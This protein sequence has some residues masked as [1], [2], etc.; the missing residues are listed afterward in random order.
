MAR[1]YVCILSFAS[2]KSLYLVTCLLRVSK[3][4]SERLVGHALLR[5]GMTTKSMCARRV[6]GSYVHVCIHIFVGSFVS[7]SLRPL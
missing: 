4:K 7:A 1:T 5:P 6:D 2:L 3:S